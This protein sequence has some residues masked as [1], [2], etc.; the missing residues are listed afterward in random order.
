M[1]KLNLGFT[2]CDEPQQPIDAQVEQHIDDDR[3]HDWQGQRIATF[4]RR[5]GHDPAKW[6]VQ[7]IRDSAYE[8]HESGA[9]PRRQQR[10]Q[11]AERKQRIDD[12]EDIVNDL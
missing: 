5:A 3:N 8:V 4:G 12:L 7:R 6:R 11:E 9:R 10:E 2:M 1:N